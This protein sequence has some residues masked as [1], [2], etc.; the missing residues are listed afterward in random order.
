MVAACLS[1]VSKNGDEGILWSSL[2]FLLEVEPTETAVDAISTALDELQGWMRSSAER[3]VELAVSRSPRWQTFLR[4]M[5]ADPKWSAKADRLLR[6][7]ASTTAP[8]D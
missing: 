1:T 8:G 4:R 7:T 2:A 5:K 3:E 6:Q